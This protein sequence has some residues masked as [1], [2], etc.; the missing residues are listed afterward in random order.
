MEAS[1][2]AEVVCAQVKE[3]VQGIPEMSIRFEEIETEAKRASVISEASQK[4][5]SKIG[6][7]PPKLVPD[8]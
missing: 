4:I 5:L 8:W 2:S 3:A 1:A 6:V 7:P